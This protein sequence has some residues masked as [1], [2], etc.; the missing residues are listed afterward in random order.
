MELHD[1]RLKPEPIAIFRLKKKKIRPTGFQFAIETGL[2]F[3]N[4]FCATKATKGEN[5]RDRV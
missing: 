1:G 2:A 5:S 3:E 4:Q